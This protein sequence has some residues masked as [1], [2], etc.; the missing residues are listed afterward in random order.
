MSPGFQEPSYS[1]CKRQII[2][3]PP[4]C[5]GE[6]ALR[7]HRTRW[8]KSR[9]FRIA[10]VLLRGEA[11]DFSK[12][13]RPDRENLRCAAWRGAQRAQN[14]ALLPLP[15]ALPDARRERCRRREKSAAARSKEYPGEMRCSLKQGAEQRRARRRA[16]LPAVLPAANIIRESTSDRGCTPKLRAGGRGG[17]WCGRPGR[18]GREAG[19]RRIAADASSA[20][21]RP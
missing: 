5:Q 7:H 8:P 9:L 4:R 21:M 6:H 14:R 15:P 10:G 1:P 13:M 18:V 20:W 12:D 17:Q 19:K 16:H 2:R 3:R 11:D